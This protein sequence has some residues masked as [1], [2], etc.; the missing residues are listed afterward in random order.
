MGTLD[1]TPSQEATLTSLSRP[2]TFPLP[3]DLQ[4]PA[5]DPYSSHAHT[6]IAQG[7]VESP[8][9]GQALSYSYSPDTVASEFL[10]ADLASTRWLDLLATDA[11][12][13]DKGFSLA[14]TRHPSPVAD[15]SGAGGLIQALQA[16]APQVQTTSAQA[17]SAPPSSGAE[18]DGTVLAPIPYTWQLGQDI[19][20][21]DHEAD[22]FRIFAERAALWLDLFDPQRHF[23]THA[24]RLAVGPTRSTSPQRTATHMTDGT[25][26][27]TWV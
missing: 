22:L 11:A 27:A 6:R 26:Y 21:R 3:S 8:D 9:A 1:R 18:L 10:T 19:S 16:S 2:H 23:S 7:G 15:A 5:G 14:P 4:E 20:L 12:E 25:S 13:A 17:A 24:T